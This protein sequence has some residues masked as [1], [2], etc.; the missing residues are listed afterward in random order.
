ML[1]ETSVNL[2]L[3]K[4]RANIPL[5]GGLSTCFFFTSSLAYTVLLNIS[6]LLCRFLSI[7]QAVPAYGRAVP[8]AS[9]DV[10]GGAGAIYVSGE[11][12]F[13]AGGAIPVAGGDV[14]VA[15]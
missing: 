10:P 11:A 15:G 3:K 4:S 1:L 14:L 13:V 7:L 9:G 2:K 12:V 5:E 8:V 6:Q